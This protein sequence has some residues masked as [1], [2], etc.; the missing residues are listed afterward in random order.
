[1]TNELG[2]LRRFVWIT[3]DE[4]TKKAWVDLVI[5]KGITKEDLILLL[6]AMGIRYEF[7]GSVSPDRSNLPEVAQLLEMC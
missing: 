5:K 3:K 6:G 2:D 7:A 4:G 1:M